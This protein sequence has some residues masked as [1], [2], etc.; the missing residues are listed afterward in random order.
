MPPA[1]VK[2]KTKRAVTAS[3]KATRAGDIA[4]AEALED[5]AEPVKK[6]RGRPKKKKEETPVS[7]PVQED[8][9]TDS[10]D[11]I[12]VEWTKELTWTLVT[13]IESDEATR[14]SLF[15]G[16]GAIKL[17]GGMPKTHF[18]YQLAITCF[19]DHPLYEESFE[20]AGPKFWRGKIKN[21][22]RSA[23][24]NMAAMSET[25][26][27]IESEAEIGT[28]TALSTKWDL[29]KI[30]SPW[31]FNMRTLIAARPNL[32]PVGLGNNET[33]IDTS[34][35]LRTNDADADDID[36]SSNGANDADD[37]STAPDDIKDGT[38][39]VE[40]NSDSDDELPAAG[41]IVAGALKRPRNASSD[42]T[43]AP[44][45]KPTKTKDRFAATVLAEEETAQRALGLKR[46][47]VK[48]Q[49]E[50]QLAKIRA[51]ADLKIAKQ[52]GDTD[53]KRRKREARTD[54]TRLRM[55]QEHQYRMAQL[56]SRSGPS[57]FAGS[58]ASSSHHVDRDSLSGFDD[59][60][61]PPLPGVGGQ[62][63]NYGD[64]YKAD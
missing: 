19:A 62:S 7:E 25:G 20:P 58:A 16:V 59:S 60:G 33:E 3:A 29:I 37:T 46:E 35:L 39:S 1:A 32:R 10:K 49:T 53:R 21:R 30:E 55:E 54:L 9:A 4:A 36:T 27:G 48:G 61:L 8:T 40:P 57:T 34:I 47:K 42:A 26:A 15:P 17:N 50:V 23:K 45:K 24:D 43:A 5:E 12:D 64:Y 22:N 41:A 44:V 2:A 52:T 28:G 31:F 18:H 63:Y 56:Q 13:A 6:K 14:D 51:E 38:R 11:E